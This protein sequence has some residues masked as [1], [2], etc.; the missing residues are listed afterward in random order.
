MGISSEAGSASSRTL[1][2]RPGAFSM[3]KTSWSAGSCTAPSTSTTD[4][5]SSASEAAK[6]TATVVLPCPGCRLV[7]VTECTRC[8]AVEYMKFV[9]SESPLCPGIEVSLA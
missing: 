5:P 8:P 3:P 1:D 2:V 7:T 9:A 4:K 6:L